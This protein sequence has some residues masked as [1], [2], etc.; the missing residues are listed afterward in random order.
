MDL[1]GFLS[2]RI[3]D[4]SFQPVSR[5]RFTTHKISAAGAVSGRFD[6]EKYAV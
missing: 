1:Y 5:F 3:Y 6:G 4:P 2:V